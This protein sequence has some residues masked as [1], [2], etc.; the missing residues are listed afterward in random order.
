MFGPLES[1]LLVHRD[2]RNTHYYIVLHDCINYMSH[3]FAVTVS[4]EQQTSLVNEEVGSL[5]VNVT[6]STANF[7]SPVFVNVATFEISG[8]AKGV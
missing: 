3:V 2:K 4:F 5:E 7:S 1:I 8:S 6:L